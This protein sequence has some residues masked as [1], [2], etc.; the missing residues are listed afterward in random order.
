MGS[1]REDGQ[2]CGKMGT[3]S[4]V[5]E[6]DSPIDGEWPPN[7]HW[8][9]RKEKGVLISLHQLSFVPKDAGIAALKGNFKM[10]ALWE[11]SPFSQSKKTPTNIQNS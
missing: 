7:S 3:N 2:T 8:N 10:H 4:T 11:K 1:G 5:E 6:G 9:P